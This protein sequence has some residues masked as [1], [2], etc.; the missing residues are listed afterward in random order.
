MPTNIVINTVLS[1]C[2]LLEIIQTSYVK[3]KPLQSN[4]AMEKPSSE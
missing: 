3:K 1:F 4:I 2:A